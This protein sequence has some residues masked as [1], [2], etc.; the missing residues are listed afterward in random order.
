MKWE[1][2]VC[3]IKFDPSGQSAAVLDQLGHEGWELVTIT[4]EVDKHGV[5]SRRAILKRPKREPVTVK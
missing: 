3:E 1:Y 4:S 5:M 2:H